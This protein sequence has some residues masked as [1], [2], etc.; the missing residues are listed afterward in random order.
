MRVF[1]IQ[2]HITNFCNLRCKHC[3]QETFD[4]SDDLIFSDIQKLFTNLSCFLK[5]NNLNLTVDITGGE[6]FLHPDFWGIIEM[7]EG[8]DVVKEYGIITNGTLLK[9]DIIKKLNSLS[10]MKTLKVSCEGIERDRFEYVRNMPYRRF[11]DILEIS[12]NFYR[13]KLL[14]FTLLEKNANQIPLLF[15]TVRKYN[16]SGF[17]VERFFPIGVGKQLKDF[18]VSRKTWNVTIRQL[19]GL[20]SLPQDLYNVAEYR[21]FKVIKKKNGWEIFGAMC[22]AGKY[23]CAIMHDGTVFPC[24]RFPLKIGNAASEPFNEIWDANPLRKI[25][26]QNLKGFCKTCKIRKCYGCRALAYC[27]YG[28]YLAVDPLCFFYEGRILHPLMMIGI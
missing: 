26:R 16:L 4:A 2:W 14:M 8:S 22:V 24:R 28:D 17:I 5:E 7:L 3:Y 11:L 12:A 18:I 10:K 6:P 23:G 1:H 19:L 27:V 15:D 13:E 20:C 25:K 9:A 21:G